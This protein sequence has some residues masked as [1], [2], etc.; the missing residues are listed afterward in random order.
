M[1]LIILA[2]QI[3]DNLNVHLDFEQMNEWIKEWINNKWIN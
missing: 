1:D 3:F 2:F